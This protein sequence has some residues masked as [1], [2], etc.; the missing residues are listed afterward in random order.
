[1]REVSQAKVYERRD[2]QEGLPAAELEEA[3]EGLIQKAR[4][5]AFSLEGSVNDLEGS[6][7]QKKFHKDVQRAILAWKAS[8][9]EKLRLVDLG[10]IIESILMICEDVPMQSRYQPMAGKKDFFPLPVPPPILVDFSEL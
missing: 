6:Y 3:V 2:G 9:D 7:S 10:E 4:K 5:E 1:M 8:R